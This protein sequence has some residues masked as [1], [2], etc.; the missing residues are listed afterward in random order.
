MWNAAVYHPVPV[1]FSLYI[2]SAVKTF[3]CLFHINN[4]NIL[5]QIP[6]HIIHDLL[7][8]HLCFNMKI[9]RLP[10]SM[11][12]GIRSSRTDDFH[13]P[14]A[15]PA[16]QIFQLSLNRVVRAVLSL[17]ALISCSL[18]LKYYFYVAQLCDLPGI[19]LSFHK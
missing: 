11:N 4:R 16:K 14:P 3:R 17:P 19:F 18:I 1:G 5:R 2:Q 10:I 12:A 6:V 7:K 9:S 8:F 13:F 15:H